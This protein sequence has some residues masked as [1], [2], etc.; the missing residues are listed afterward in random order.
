MGEAGRDK[1]LRDFD[2]DRKIDRMLKIYASAST[3][4]T[5]ISPSP[6]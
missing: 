3:T 6:E 2:W 4:Y 1:L 5:K